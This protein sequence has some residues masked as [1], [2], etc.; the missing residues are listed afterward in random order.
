MPDEE[1]NQ[2][3]D[4]APETSLHAHGSGI[5]EENERPRE[6][7]AEGNIVEEGEDSADA[8]EKTGGATSGGPGGH[9]TGEADPSDVEHDPNEEDPN[10]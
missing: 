2:E 9:A 8:A 4:E 5:E 7:Q 3:I 1:G 10:D 6:D